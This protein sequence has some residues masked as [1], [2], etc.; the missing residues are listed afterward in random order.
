MSRGKQ[1][2]VKELARSS[3]SA[4]EFFAIPRGNTFLSKTA[5]FRQLRLRD[6]KTYK[7]G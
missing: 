7:N 2:R 5:V 4:L 3:L 1:L 6:R